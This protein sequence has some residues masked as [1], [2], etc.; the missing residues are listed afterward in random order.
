MDEERER[1]AR[2]KKGT[3]EREEGREEH[4]SQQ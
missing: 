3:R 4:K 2:V 1:E